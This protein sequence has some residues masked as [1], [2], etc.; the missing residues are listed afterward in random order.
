MSTRFREIPNNRKSNLPMNELT[1]LKIA[2]SRP[3]NLIFAGSGALLALAREHGM[4]PDIRRNALAELVVRWC[5]TNDS[6]LDGDLASLLA[7]TWRPFADWY[8]AVRPWTGRRSLPEDSRAWPEPAGI[9]GFVSV[10]RR[11]LARSFAADG[12]IPLC[13][14]REA[15]FVPFQLAKDV[16]GAVW[17]DGEEIAVWREPVCRALSG[18]G[19]TGIRLQL[20]NGPE[21]GAGVQGNSLM[22]PVRMAALRGQEDGLPEYDVLQVLATGAFDDRFRLVD[23]ELR[24]KFDAMKSQD[25]D[26]FLIGPDVPGVIPEDERAFCRLDVGLDE[27]GVMKAIRDRLERTEGCV[28]MAR[29]YVLRR[30][31]DMMAHV[32]RENHH[33]WNEVAAQLEGF[34]KSSSFSSRRNPEEWL[35]FM[36]LLATAY[37]HAGRTED[38]RK[39]TLEA[40]EFA[41]VSGYTAKALRL[42]VTAA[43]NAQDMGEIDEYKTLAAGLEDELESFVGPERDDLLMR[44]HGTAAQMHVFGVVYGIAGFTVAEAMEHVEKAINA[45]ETIAN[46]AEPAKKDESE[47]NVAQDLNYRHLLFA[48][49]EPG[50]SSERSAFDEACGQL[51]NIPST[52]SVRNNRYHQMRQKSL[53]YF[54]AWR[55]GAEVPSEDKRNEVRL[56][57]GDA[58]GW[59]VAANRRHL[60]A[61][62]AAVGEAEEAKKCFDEGEKALPLDKCWA[63]VLGSIRFALLVQAA[64]SLQEKDATTAAAYYQKAD[65]V[66]AKFGE[67]KLFMLMNA[68]RWMSLGRSG[69][70]PR[71]LPQFYY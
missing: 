42:Q 56:P 55:N 46:A 3:E 58:E 32:D 64:C 70:D 21:L 19:R 15:W 47:S 48:L 17:S 34:L 24:P 36:S 9:S 33:R 67:S 11:R 61:L 37:C 22:L 28:Y 71:N 31:P 51:N 7:P 20:R 23:V 16:A 2:G 53:A 63:P 52:K 12:F 62:A 38:S 4:S 5:L 1:L 13:R 14:G 26:A 59:F 44:F 45:A 65:E 30:L 18:T 10:L 8:R 35:E 6:K 41:K 25:L 40:L 27:Q 66:K 49:F 68:D 50:S 39:C 57:A 54:N 69:T 43:V 60:G 29:D